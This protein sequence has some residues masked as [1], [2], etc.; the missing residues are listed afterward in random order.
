MVLD[1]SNLVF[2]LDI[3]GQKESKKKALYLCSQMKSYI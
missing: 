2:I 3:Q 1:N